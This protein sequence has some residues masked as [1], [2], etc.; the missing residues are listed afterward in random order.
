ME[1]IN[2]VKVRGRVGNARVSVVGDRSVCRF[3]V[4]TNSVYRNSDN[5]ATEEVTWHNCNVWSGK[6]LP[7]P[8]VIKVGAG[9]EIEGR[10][11]TNKYTASDGTEKF[12]TEIVV[13]EIKFLPENEPLTAISSL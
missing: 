13:G 5:I 11:R 6:R 12:S 2:Y 10:L 1:Q 4:A 7:D 3:S 9:V 8:G